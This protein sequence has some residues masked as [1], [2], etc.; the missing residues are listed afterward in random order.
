V[1]AHD[2]AHR[3][4]VPYANPSLRT[5]YQGNV[6]QNLSRPTPEQVRPQLQ[7]QGERFGNRQVPRNVAPA[8]NR[9]VFGGMENGSAARQNADHGYSSMGPARSSPAPRAAPAP[10][11]SGGGGGGGRPAGGGGGNARPAGGG[12]GRGGR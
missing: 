2:A 10:R 4:G 1:W 12:G 8:Q 6:R 7:Q 3:A 11:P 9:G 5:Q